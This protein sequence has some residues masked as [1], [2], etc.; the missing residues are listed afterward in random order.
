MPRPATHDP[1]PSR[2]RRGGQPGN[3]NAMRH[4]RHSRQVRDIE[5]AAE[6]LRR[7]APNVFRV[8]NIDR[9]RREQMARAL[10][11]A[12]DLLLVMRPHGTIKDVTPVVI[13]KA[14]QIV[15]SEEKQKNERTDRTQSPQERFPSKALRPLD[16]EAGQAVE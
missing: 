14:V 2:R 7:W 13:Q 10:R 5:L 11:I 1:R 9:R 3:T 12:A 15:K 8:A 6:A 4:G 16:G